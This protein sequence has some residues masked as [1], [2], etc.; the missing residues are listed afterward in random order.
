MM[1]SR[2][3]TCKILTKQ[4]IFCEG[5][6]VKYTLPNIKTVLG[7]L[8]CRLCPLPLYILREISLRTMVCHYIVAVILCEN[9]LVV[10]V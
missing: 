10:C 4:S 8:F 2:C 3:D 9:V 7:V 6:K 5:I 1:M